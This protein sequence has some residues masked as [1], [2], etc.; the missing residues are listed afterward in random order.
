MFG[1]CKECWREHDLAYY[2]ANAEKCREKS[3][4]WRRKNPEKAKAALDQYLRTHRPQVYAK[5]KRYRDRHR[6][7]IR[8]RNK[9]ARERDPES[10]RAAKRAERE[11]NR[12]WYRA[13][14]EWRYYN[15]P[16]YKEAVKARAAAWNRAHPEVK[17]VY[18]HVRRARRYKAE[19]SHTADDICRL[20]EQQGARCYYCQV[21]LNGRFHVDHKQPRSKGGSE[22]PENLACTC[23][24]CNLRK[25]ALT[26]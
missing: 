19:G 11:R 14:E 17:L 1:W 4:T 3:R 18:G 10:T 9:A 23:A 20:Y 24:T 16:G 6:D 25:G 12:D 21:P 7:E 26:E 22:W 13:Y 2:A 15:K 8:A 5:N